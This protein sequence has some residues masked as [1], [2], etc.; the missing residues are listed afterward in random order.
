MFF[1]PAHRR[2]LNHEGDK[3]VGDQKLYHQT[4]NVYVNSKY[5]YE[6]D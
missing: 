3:L 1:D 2:S 6:H 5:F 4:V